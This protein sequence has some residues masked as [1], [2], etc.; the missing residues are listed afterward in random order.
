MVCCDDVGV[1]VARLL[2]YPKNDHPINAVDAE[3]DS[4]INMVA[5]FNKH[6]GVEWRLSLHLLPPPPP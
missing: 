3:A 6:L 4:F 5:W 2:V 1:S